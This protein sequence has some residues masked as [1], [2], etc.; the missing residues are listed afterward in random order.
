MEAIFITG[1]KRFPFNQKVFWLR[2][3]S[4]ITVLDHFQQSC[5]LPVVT[6]WSATRLISA[7]VTPRLY[8]H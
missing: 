8:P 1:T 6:S 2:I 3:Q 5:Q 4:S 7:P